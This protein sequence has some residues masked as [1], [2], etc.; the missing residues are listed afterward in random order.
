MYAGWYNTEW[1]T[2][3]NQKSGGLKSE[4]RISVWSKDLGDKELLL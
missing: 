2:V 1:G 4:L 3:P